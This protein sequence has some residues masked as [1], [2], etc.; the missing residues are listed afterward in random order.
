MNYSNYMI[1][2]ETLGTDKCLHGITSIGIVQFA[3]TDAGVFVDCDETYR[4]SL[5]HWICKDSD[6]LEWRDRNGVDEAEMFLD[7]RAHIAFML[8][9]GGRVAADPAA[10][11]W[12]KPANFDI[13]F[14][15][16]YW[17]RHGLE[18]PWHHRNVRDLRSFC[19]GILQPKDLQ[20]RVAEQYAKMERYHV[21]YAESSFMELLGRNPHIALADC[22]LQL[23]ILNAA[24][25]L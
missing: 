16:S 18:I 7:A 11:V 5:P 21:A 13:G 3:I 22:Y 4:L 23:D 25:L 8:D 6:T 17:N 10:C 14:L 2:I 24:V 19:E 15:E 12:G 20:Y 9:F 1:D